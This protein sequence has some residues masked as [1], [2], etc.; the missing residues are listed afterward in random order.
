MAWQKWN[1]APSRKPPKRSWS[2]EEMKMIG[3]V[4]KKG[5]NIGISPDWKHEYQHWQIDIKIGNGK[6]HTDPNRYSDE[7]VHENVIKYYKYYYEKYRN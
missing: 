7:D 5:I 2:K 3:F 1:R 4:M 6:V